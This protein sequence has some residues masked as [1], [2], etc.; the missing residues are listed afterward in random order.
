M[1][2]R[3]RLGA[4]MALAMATWTLYG[5]AIT[6]QALDEVWPRIKALQDSGDWA[7]AEAF[8]RGSWARYPTEDWIGLNLSYALRRLGRNAEAK[9][10]AEAIYARGADGAAREL[11]YCLQ[12]LGWER[13]NAGDAAEAL[14]L[15]E[16]SLALAP[17]DE[18]GLNGK[19][20]A[21]ALAGRHVEAIAL[22]DK[23]HSLYPDNPHVAGNL[24]AAHY[25]RIQA[26]LGAGSPSEALRAAREARWAFPDEGWFMWYVSEAAMRVDAAKATGDSAALREAREALEAHGALLKAGHAAFD[27]AEERTAAGKALYHGATNLATRLLSLGRPD[28]AIAFAKGLSGSFPYPGLELQLEGHVRA[29]AGDFQAGLAM[30]EEAWRLSPARAAIEAAPLVVLPPLRGIYLVGGNASKEY[31]THAGLNRFCYDFTGADASGA[32]TLAGTKGLGRIQDWVGY[33]AEVR[34][35][36]G[37]VVELVRIGAPDLEPS[38]QMRVGTGNQV[39]VLDDEG[40]HHVYDHLMARSIAV[41]PG[42]RIEEGA[43]LGRLGNSGQTT[44]PHLHYGVYSPDWLYSLPVKFSEFELLTSGAAKA[45]IEAFI[46]DKALVRFR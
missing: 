41:S 32:T 39:I 30:V 23:A 21:L 4:A 31:I 45:M 34:A 2:K 35:T 46:P 19:G 14:A 8:A 7:G 5:P 20:W 11:A 36:K 1:M 29:L 25:K 33:G 3:A 24:K 40:R 6:A 16:R 43:L 12:G 28:E 17:G 44:A 15:F 13:A 26:S 18:W 9:A 37:G 27:S 42:Q 38:S 10:I 22:L